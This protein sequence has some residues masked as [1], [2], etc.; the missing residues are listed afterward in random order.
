VDQRDIQLSDVAI[1]L[2]PGT[3]TVPLQ[4]LVHGLTLRLAPDAITKLAE[5]AVKMASA[6]APVDVQ[7]TGCRL[8]PGA[9]EVKARAG[10]GFM[11]ADVTAQ[12]AISA[13]GDTVRVALANLNAPRWL[14]TGSMIEMALGKATQIAGIRPDPQNNQ[15]VLVNPA[16]VLARQGVPARLAPGAW[17]VAVTP[18]A[19]DLSYRET[20]G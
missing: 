2:E 17:D 3:D 5:E 12:L 11:G 19:L 1:T 16:E 13:A 9:I 7:L 14:P 6:K 4:P 8:I 18:V 10:K 15:A 20:S